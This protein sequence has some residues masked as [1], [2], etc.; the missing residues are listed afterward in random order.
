MILAFIPSA[1]AK[2]LPPK[3]LRLASANGRS[4]ARIGNLSLDASHRPQNDEKLIP[5][6]AVG[7]SLRKSESVIP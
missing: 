1:T 5:T 6:K 7:F 2:R 4:E 3:A